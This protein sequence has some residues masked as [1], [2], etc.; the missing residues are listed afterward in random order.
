[1]TQI[2]NSENELISIIDNL[3]KRFSNFIITYKKKENIKNDIDTKSIK[4]NKPL[5][6]GIK[7]E[8]LI[9]SII[10]KC[11]LNNNYFNTQTVNE[12]G[13]SSSNIDI[14]CNY[15]S[16]NDIGIEVKKYR[17]PHWTQCTLIHS[18]NKWMISNRSKLPNNVKKVFEDILHQINIF[19]GELPPFLN[20]DYTYEQW[21]NIRKNTNKWNN[22]YYDISDDII[23]KVYNTRGCHYIQISDGYGLYH[24]GDDICKFN[25]PEFNVKQCLYIKV[26]VTTKKKI[27]GYCSI[28]VIAT[29]KPK[30][31]K[32]LLKSNYS[33]D[34][35][36][37]LPHN[38]IYYDNK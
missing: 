26:K 5:I 19:D 11:K 27:N 10:N 21:I 16:N 22:K 37:K 15:K 3:N 28:S 38:L 6:E 32:Y 13:R 9:H 1:M 18:D 12:L 36:N 20:N 23:K 34:D 31:M 30:N 14:S 7:Y 25:V 24:L 2:N 29:L 8:R 33:L 17:T 35:V 4:G